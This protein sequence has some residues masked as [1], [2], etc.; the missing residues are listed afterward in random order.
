MNQLQ[1]SIDQIIWAIDLNNYFHHTKL[2]NLV[3]TNLESIIVSVDLVIKSATNITTVNLSLNIL[4]K[5]YEFII[6]FFQSVSY[7]F[8]FLYLLKFILFYFF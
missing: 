8:I 6:Y 7:N 5:F 2:A 1:I 4:Q 3:Y